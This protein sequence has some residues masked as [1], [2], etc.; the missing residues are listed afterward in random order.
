MGVQVAG[1]QAVIQATLPLRFKFFLDGQAVLKTEPQAS[2]RQVQV[3][4]S[5]TV[6]EGRARENTPAQRA[7]VGQV[8]MQADTPRQQRMLGQG[9]RRFEGWHVGHGRG[10][11]DDPG[12]ER[13]QNHR[14]FAS[15]ETEVVSV[16][17]DLVW[18]VHP[19]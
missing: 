4:H 3:E 13:S 14:V 16:D 5:G 8:E 1:A 15:A 19:P 2:A 18:H 10:G 11:T 17:Y 12:L 7:A 6:T 9:T